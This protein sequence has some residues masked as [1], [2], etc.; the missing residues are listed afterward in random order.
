M[1]MSWNS[2]QGCKRQQD[3][4]AI[5]YIECSSLRN[6]GVKTVFDEA[7]RLAMKATNKADLESACV[8]L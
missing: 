1:S 6:K 8:I 4:G 7:I 5:K 2:H 3:I